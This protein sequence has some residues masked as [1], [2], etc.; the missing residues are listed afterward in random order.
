MVRRKLNRKEI[1]LWV[2]ASVM[3][4]LTL[5]FYLWHITEN[6]R[7]GYDIGR[8]EV[9]KQELRDEIK[10]LETQR[11]ALRSLELVERIARKDLGMT[12]TREDQ[13]IYKDR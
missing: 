7:L 13:I 6:V 10:R 4:I 2:L 11:A 9:R 3:T 1:A 12:E 8:G 5:T